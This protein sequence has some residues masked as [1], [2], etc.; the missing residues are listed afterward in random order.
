MNSTY[1]NNKLDNT[2]VYNGTINRIR[3]VQF[4][5]THEV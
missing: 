4:L 5:H 3:Y 2:D 1:N